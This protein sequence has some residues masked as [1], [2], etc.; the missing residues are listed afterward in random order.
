MERVGGGA[1]VGLG[2]GERSDHLRELH[3][4]SGPA[5]RDEERQ[6]T[7]MF[8]S[9]MDEVHRQTVNRRRELLQLVEAPLLCAPVEAV[10][11]VRDQL[12]QV[13]DVGAVRPA[14]ALQRLRNP[15]IR[16]ARLEIGED[17]VGDSNREWPDGVGRSLPGRGCLPYSKQPHG[18]RG[19]DAQSTDAHTLLVV[20]SGDGLVHQHDFLS[21]DP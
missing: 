5:V 16:Q 13:S 12:T 21:F 18:D 8:R 2:I 4:R 10:A 20:R 17:A 19:T 15:R 1:T 7:R 3:E 9:A 14:V 11:P 6:G